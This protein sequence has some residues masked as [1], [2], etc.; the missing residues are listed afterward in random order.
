MLPLSW[1]LS[2]ET[3]QGDSTNDTTQNSTELDAGILNGEPLTPD[4]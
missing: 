2:L 3:G 1:S 4:L